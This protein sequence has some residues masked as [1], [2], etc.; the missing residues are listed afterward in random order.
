MNIMDSAAAM[1]PGL[2]GDHS[3]LS[4]YG[5]GSP[6]A[7]GGVSSGGLS[8][9][10]GAMEAALRRGEREKHMELLVSCLC[11]WYYSRVDVANMVSSFLLRKLNSCKRRSAR[12]T[13]PSASSCTSSARYLL[14]C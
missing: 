12:R 6:G 10:S 3:G 14:A 4:G 7:C 8:S 9:N 2:G 11:T 13:R 5:Y 1:T